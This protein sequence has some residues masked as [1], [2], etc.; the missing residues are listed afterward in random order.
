LVLSDP[1]FG[2]V[3]S[4][5]AW[6]SPAFWSPTL[7]EVGCLFLYGILGS[8][9]SPAFLGVTQGQVGGFAYPA[10]QPVCKTTF[11]ATLSRQGLPLGIPTDLWCL[12]PFSYF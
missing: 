5:S 6:C 8:G 1:S 10:L 3:W 11:E 9:A 2:M 12:S 4:L 7:A